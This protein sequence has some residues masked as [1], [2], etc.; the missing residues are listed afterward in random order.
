MPRRRNIKY[1]TESHVSRFE[2]KINFNTLE[3]KWFVK[4]S[5][6]PKT[7]CNHVYICLTRFV[8]IDY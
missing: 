6:I 3:L 8:F 5:L 1:C 4:K 7:V 2:A